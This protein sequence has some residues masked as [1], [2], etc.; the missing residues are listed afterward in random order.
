MNTPDLSRVRWL[1]CI[2]IAGLLWGGITAIPLQ[3]ELNW[4]VQLLRADRPDAGAFSLWL[5]KVRDALNDTYAHYPFIAYGT[6]WLAFGHFMLAIAFLWPLKDPVRY[7][8]LFTFGLI[9]CILVVPFAMVAGQVRGIP[10]G[11]RL[12]DCSF[13]IV[14]FVPLWLCRR[15]TQ[16]AHAGFRG[17]SVPASRFDSTNGYESQSGSRGRS[18]H[19]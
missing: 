18:P 15:Y 8:G 7:S 16:A 11:W 13:G 3:S 4:I 14:G 10:W 6:D 5:V 19:Q 1:T 9:A 2:V 17:A 12:I